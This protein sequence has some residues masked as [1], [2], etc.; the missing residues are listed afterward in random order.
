MDIQLADVLLHIDENLTADRRGEVEQ[1]LRGVDGVVSVHNPDAR[2]HL[3]LVQYRPD[4]VNSQALL[5]ATLAEGI[6]AELVGL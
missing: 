2:P 1:R 6:H 3:T 5:K 4:K